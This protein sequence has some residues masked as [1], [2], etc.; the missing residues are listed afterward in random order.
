[1]D[2]NLAK[3]FSRAFNTSEQFPATV[4]SFGFSNGP[5]GGGRFSTHRLVSSREALSEG[6]G[7]VTIGLVCVIPN[8]L[9]GGLAHP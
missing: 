1:M 8:K 4:S 9:I 3:A 7:H 5:E 6:G 2:I